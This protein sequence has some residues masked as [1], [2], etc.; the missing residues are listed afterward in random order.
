LWLDFPG[1]HADI[2]CAAEGI[3]HAFASSPGRD[4]ELDACV[5]F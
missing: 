3:S 2:H 5:L 1:D 4:I